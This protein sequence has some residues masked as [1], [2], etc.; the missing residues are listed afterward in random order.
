MVWDNIKRYYIKPTPYS[1]EVAKSNIET[2]GFKAW[3]NFEFKIIDCTKKVANGTIGMQ[4]IDELYKT[5]IS[6][7]YDMILL[8]DK[9]I[10]KEYLDKL[11]EV[12]KAN[13]F[14]EVENPPVDRKFNKTKT[15]KTRSGSKTKQP[16]QPKEPK[17]TAAERKAKAKALKIA[18][19]SIN[20]NLK[21]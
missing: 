4:T 11:Y 18:S 14:Y 3:I 17:E 15:V 10:Q 1:I 7:I 9:E 20:L 13:L 12:H 16:K 6:L 5:E 21:K 19:L 8:Q 2:Q